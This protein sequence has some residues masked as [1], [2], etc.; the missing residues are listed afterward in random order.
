MLVKTINIPYWK[1]NL[2]SSFEELH[3]NFLSSIK[4]HEKIST[5]N[6]FLFDSLYF[7]FNVNLIFR[8]LYKMRL[9]SL[10]FKLSLF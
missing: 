1:K 4:Y 9:K 2:T 8:S 10:I 7:S 3:V 5:L 6:K